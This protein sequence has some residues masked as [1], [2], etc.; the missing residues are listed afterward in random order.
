MA[1][2]CEKADCDVSLDGIARRDLVF[3][4]E[5]MTTGISRRIFVAKGN[6]VPKLIDGERQIA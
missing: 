4:V 6:K 3:V 5:T 2:D 1:H